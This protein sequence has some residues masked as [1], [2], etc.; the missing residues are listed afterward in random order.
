M[1]SIIRRAFSPYPFYERWRY[2]RKIKQLKKE[3][4]AAFKTKL[5]PGL[6]REITSYW[7]SFGLKVNLDWHRGYIGIR[8]GENVHR[9]IPEDIYYA[10]IE[11]A[12]SRHE[13]ADSYADKNYYDR[14]FPD[15]RGPT[16]LLRRINGRY[17]DRNYKVLTPKQANELLS[18]HQGDLIVKPSIE[19]GNGTNVRKLTIDNGRLAFGDESTDFEGISK[20]YG[21]DFLAQHVFQQ[22]PAMAAF[23][24]TSVNTVRFYTLRLDD[25]IKVISAVFRS[26]NLGRC[27][28]N[29]GI[30][31]GINADG[32]LNDHANTKYFTKYD[33]HPVTGK[34][35]RGF[36]IPGWQSACEF[37]KRLHEQLL[38]FDS[39]SWDI[40][41]NP[42]SQPCLMEINLTF[43]EINF[44]QVNNGP[45]YGD[46]TDEVLARV[47][48]RVS[49][50]RFYRYPLLRTSEK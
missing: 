26:G 19:S 10:Y 32:R 33:A 48:K 38:Y 36:V 24:P 50:R 44:H 21:L 25:E 4:P 39:V 8:G 31:C 12:F 13:L 30:P 42:D 34:A 7:R 46:L 47:F 18:G 27:V 49:P 3:Y 15:I 16:T 1:S 22:H 20:S 5:A 37:V 28:D 17:Y 45:L 41:I 35:F 23:H 29:R 2:V 9:Y 40:T 11:R 14:L 6:E 43:Q